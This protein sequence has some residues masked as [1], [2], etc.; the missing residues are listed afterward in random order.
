MDASVLL[1]YI[2]PEVVGCSTP[3]ALRATID[4]AREFCRKTRACWMEQQATI[5]QSAITDGEATLDLTTPA[6][7][8][9]YVP[10]QVQI[11]GRTVSAFPTPMLQK[12][13]VGDIS[14]SLG[15]GTVTLGG[16]PNRDVSISAV[17]ALM[18][19]QTAG[20]IPDAVEPWIEAVASGAKWRLLATPQTRWF[21]PDNANFNE[22][23]FRSGIN[24]ARIEV[25]RRL[26]GPNIIAR[27]WR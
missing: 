25:N 8:Q 27:P 3:A 23:L 6:G 1:P 18:P 19:A 24:C 7:Q 14:Y 12:L 16:L 13:R 5:P 26:Y 20:T 22:Q 11:D 2:L 21:S 9:I 4:A 10:V 17:W 15:E